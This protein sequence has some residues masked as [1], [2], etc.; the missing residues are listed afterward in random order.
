MRLYSAG[1]PGP[2]AARLAEVV[3]GGRLDDP[4][5]PEWLAVPSDGMRRWLMLELARHLGSSGAGRGDGIAAN[6]ERAYPGTLRSRVL[7]AERTDAAADPWSIDRL[8]WS[9]L[10][11][12]ERVV[13]EPALA[14][15]AAVPQG[16]SRFAR[17]RR[18]ADLFDRYHL[19]RPD[20]VRS[21]AAG[22]FVDGR[23]MEIDEHAVWQPRLWCLVRDEVGEESPPERLPELLA[24]IRAGTLALDLPPRLL[25]FGFT[26]LPGEGFL[27][28]AEAVAAQRD[29]HLFLLQPSHFDPARMRARPAEQVRHPLLRSWGRIPRETAL[30][31][32]DAEAAGSAPV[33]HVGLRPDARPASTLLARLQHDIRSDSVPGP[34]PVAPTDRS[35]Q[36]HACYGPMRQVQ[37]L[38]DALLHL[39]GQPDSDLTEE[40]IL[41][42]CPALDR[43][44]PLIDAVFGAGS[45]PGEPGRPDAGAEP[46]GT[47]SLRFRIADRSIRTTN[48]MLGATAAL[49]ELVSG[50]FEVPAVLDFLA[51]GPVRECFRFDDDDLTTITEWVVGTEVR[52]GFDPRHR[53][54]FGVPEAIVANTWQFAL[55]RLLLGVA[56]HDDDHHLAVGDVAPFGVEGADVDVLGR[57]AEAIRLLAGLADGARSTRSVGEWI[58]VVRSA[59]DALLAAP[60]DAPWQMEGLRRTLAEVLE[61]ATCDGV[62]STVPLEFLD[63]RRL[64]DDHLDG[65]VGRPDFF[66]GGITITSMTPLRWVPF[67]VVCV[68]GMDQAAFGAPAAAADDLAAA[69]P[70]PGDPDPRAE[71]RQALLEV[72]LAAGDHLLV[73]RDGRDVRTNQDIPRSVVLAE[74][75]DAVLELVEPEGRADVARVLEVHHPRHPFDEACFS[76]GALGEAG[77]WGFDSSDLDGALARR[78]RSVGSRPFL[79]DRLPPRSIEVVD[80]A[81]L[82]TFLAHPVA[83]FVTRSLEARLPHREERLSALLPVAPDALETWRIGERMLASKLDGVGRA[84]W[85]ELER[86]RGT[87]PPGLLETRLVGELDD[88]VD[89]IVAEADALGV[90]RGSPELVDIDVVLDDGT[91]IV[92]AVPIRL[93]PDTPGPARVQYGVVK[94]VHHVA[95][96]VDLM[97]LAATD[98]VAGWRSVVVGRR[99]GAASAVDAIE[100]TVAGPD[101]ADRVDPRGALGVAVDCYRRGMSEPIPLFPRLSH[102]QHRSE[103]KSGHWVAFGGGGDGEHAAVRL[104][105]AGMDFR[106]LMDLPAREDDPPGAGG[107]VQRF[108]SYLWGTI[109]RSVTAFDRASAAAQDAVPDG[110]P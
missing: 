35:I 3:G 34:G 21:W 86:A 94:P 33:E 110:K 60:R 32:A 38:R 70:R 6:I 13:D 80:L 24:R 99:P 82:H 2:L 7:N 98:P 100:L 42:V 25:L 106:S 29:V 55:D 18:I 53:A 78:H 88:V 67:R 36:V 14:A 37:V 27:D 62:I 108:A 16:A 84:D 19:H 12:A 75:R 92:G 96:W 15:F 58:A 22:A 43:F 59:A 1:H 10:E 17:A 57:L 63:L 56:V 79:E 50:R 20:M 81:E 46:D 107:R 9:V 41:V 39:L 109:D 105:F 104:A 47:P 11:V 44:A 69:A 66:R 30:L 73:V 48:P 54:R 93:D 89:A 28:L 101:T 40:D 85:L 51:L 76:P 90:R 83:G 68:L 4:M 64:V 77:A 61:S 65:K 103:A 8:A 72:V 87:L 45:L 31:L 26:Q 71:V 23:G 95:A 91:H 5:T 49:L 102:E 52:W 74:L 97:A